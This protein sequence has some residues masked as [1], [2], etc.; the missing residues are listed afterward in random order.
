MQGENVGLDELGQI[1]FHE[2]RLALPFLQVVLL[3][4]NHGVADDVFVLIDFC[5]QLTVAA[6]GYYTVEGILIDCLDD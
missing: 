6:V 3:L 1:S 2:N 5:F 4:R